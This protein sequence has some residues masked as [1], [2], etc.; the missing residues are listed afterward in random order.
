MPNKAY[1]P[2]ENYSYPL[3]IKKLLNTPLVYSPDQ[4][5]IYR[6]KTRMTYRMLYERIHRLANALANLGVSQGDTVAVFDYDSNRYLECFFARGLADRQLASVRGSDC[7][8]AQ[9]Y[10]SRH[11]SDQF[12]FP[13]YS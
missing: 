7:L 6:D 2:G 1:Q 9:S 5:I 10:R 11:D 4:E 8:Y 3:I 12:R 13:P